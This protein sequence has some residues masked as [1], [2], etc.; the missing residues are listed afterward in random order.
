[1]L[2]SPPYPSLRAFAV[3][4][5]HS[6][7]RQSMLKTDPSGRWYVYNMVCSSLQVYDAAEYSDLVAKYEK[8]NWR[9]ISKPGGATMKPDHFYQLYG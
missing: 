7:P 9:I 6:L 2:L 1:M 3:S 5:H 8:L 4:H